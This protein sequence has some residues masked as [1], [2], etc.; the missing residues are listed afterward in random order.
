MYIHQYVFIQ[1][2][3]S[4]WFLPLTRACERSVSRE[5]AKSAAQSPLTCSASNCPKR[6]H[7]PCSVRTRY[8]AA[9]NAPQSKIGEGHMTWI[10][11]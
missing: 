2:L 3:S 7:K 1:K 10:T 8:R 5:Q 4:F 9:Y 6:V 11:R